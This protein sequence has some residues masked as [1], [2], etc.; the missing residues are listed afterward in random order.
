MFVPVH[1]SAL[2]LFRLA[3]PAASTLTLPTHTLTLSHTQL[4]RTACYPSQC[5]PFF[6]PF[7]FHRFPRLPK[8]IEVC[9]PFIH[10]WLLAVG[11]RLA[12]SNN[13]RCRGTSRTLLVCMCCLF[14]QPSLAQIGPSTGRVTAP[15]G[16]PLNTQ[17]AQRAG[18]SSTGHVSYRRSPSTA[19]TMGRT[20]MMSRMSLVTVVLFGRGGRAVAGGGPA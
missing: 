12:G 5:W 20:H 1:I 15:M 16:V 2:A 17:H 11:M 14:L 9:F 18:G 8:A 10:F 3:P 4:C 7:C 13:L 6:C 19:N